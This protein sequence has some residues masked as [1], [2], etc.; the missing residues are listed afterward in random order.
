MLGYILKKFFYGLLVILGVV[1]LIFI[2][3]NTLPGDPARMMLGQH[4]DPKAIEAINKELGLDK[5]LWKQYVLYLNDLMPL[6]VH[7]TLNKEHSTWFDNQKYHGKILLKTSAGY[8]LALK[9]PYLR[10]SSVSKREV[11]E[12]IAASLPQTALLAAVSMLFASLL[13]ILIGS[14]IA[15]KKGTWIDNFFLVFTVF[16]MAGPSFFMAVLVAWLF[17]FVLAPYTGLNMTGSLYY[18][19][20]FGAG[21]YLQLKNLI[22][23]AFTLGIRPLSVIVQLARSSFLDVL[24]QDYIRTARAKGLS[25]NA[26]LY[27]HALRNALNPIVTAVSGWFAGLLAGAVFIE[28]IFGWKGIGKEIVDALEN[29]DF[30]V[31]MGGVLVISLAFVLINIVVD[32]IYGILDPR[33]SIR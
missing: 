6:S 16:G 30:P 9:T 12:I 22:L 1:T 21:S 24:S 18:I 26:V 14:F 31:V 4:S 17:G 19:D 28:Y 11:S 3:F 27:K 10:R 8:G 15:V 29:Y 32:I 33:V 7:N 2:L 5:P 23:P 25:K 20:D 13:G